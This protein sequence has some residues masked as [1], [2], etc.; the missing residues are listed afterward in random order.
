VSQTG[1]QVGAVAGLDL[2]STPDLAANPDH[3]LLVA[4]SFWEWK[5]INALCNQAGFAQVTRRINGG[6]NGMV[7]RRQWLSKVIRILGQDPAGTARISTADVIEV[8]RALQESGYPEVGAADGLIGSRTKAAISRF[9][10]DNGL[11]PG[12]IDNVLKNALGIG[13]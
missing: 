4:C 5:N 7:D 6:M 9:R 13:D 11:E 2:V 12:L 10:Q 3:A 1:Q 8:Q